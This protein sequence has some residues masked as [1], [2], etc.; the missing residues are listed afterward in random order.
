MFN[1]L[2]PLLGL[3]TLVAL[4][5]LVLI[6]PLRRSIITRPIFSTYRKVPLRPAPSG[7]RGSCSGARPTGKS[8]TATRSRN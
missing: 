4:A 8:C 5:G 2:I 6:R 3:V 1:N 7:G